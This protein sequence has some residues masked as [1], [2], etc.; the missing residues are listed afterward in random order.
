MMSEQEQIA[1]LKSAL[2]VVQTA[3]ACHRDNQP[4]VHPEHGRLALEEVK[5]LIVDPALGEEPVPASQ[6]QQT[7]AREVTQTAQE[8]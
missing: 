3:L 1:K 6:E 8:N 2:T 4:Y 5:Y 7:H